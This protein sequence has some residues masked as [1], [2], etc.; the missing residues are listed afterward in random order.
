MVADGS[1][2]GLGVAVTRGEGGDGPLTRLLT[3]GGATVLDWGVV[4]VGPPDDPDPLL[5]ALEDL[6]AYDWICFS[7]P[8]AV[9]AV[10]SRVSLPPPG[11]RMAAVGPSTAS[12][13]ADAGWPVH[14]VP[15][16]GTGEELVEAFCRAD[17]VRGL[18]VFFP[19]SVVARNVI[20]SGL[21][22]LGAEVD[23]VVAYRLVTLPIDARACQA[24]LDNGQVH[25]ILFASPS[26]LK[27]LRAGLGEDLFRRLRAEVPAAVMGPTTAEAVQSAGWRRIAVATEPTFRGLVGAA[28][29][30]VAD[31][32]PGP[33][34]GRSSVG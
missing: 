4:T 29:R 16:G 2:Q 6:S 14:R 27:A 34:P 17:D 15:G 3:E 20:P 25:V 13:L 33:V 19:A 11:V 1:L 5:A 8:R 30:A 21:A 28:E 9:D 31:P 10:V 12:A 24:S 26:A 7:S 23:Q 32:Y 18:R 22:A